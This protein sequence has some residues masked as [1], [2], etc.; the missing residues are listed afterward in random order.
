[1]KKA[2][3]AILN[4]PWSIADGWLETIASI[5]EREHEYAGN[6]EALQKKLGRPLGNTRTVTVRDGVAI[7]PIE[8]P[9]FSKANLFT[10]IS[11]LTSYDYLALE[12]T[13]AL[14]DPNIRAIIADFDTPGGSVNGASELSSMIR[15]ARGTKPMV[16]YVNGQMAS[17]GLWIGSA[18]DK[19][20]A[21]DTAQI[22]SVG[23]QMGATVREPR[24]GEKTYRFVSSQSPLKNADLG[25]DAGA[26]NAQKMVDDLAQVFIDTL[27]TNRNQDTE[28]VAEN[29]GQGAVFV[30]AEAL[31]RGMIDSISTF[32]TVF[33]T[34]SEE[35]NS[36]EYKQLTVAA[37]TENRPDLVA[38]I[39]EDAIATIDKP[40]LAAV[41]AEGATAERNRLLSIEALSMP[42]AEEII[43]AAKADPNA[44]AEATAVK[45]L[46]AV[47]AGAVAPK[48]ED[49]AAA[50]LKGIM[51]TEAALDKPVPLAAKDA[52]AEDPA[53]FI[54]A[55]AKAAGLGGM[56]Q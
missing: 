22:G 15:E 11:A 3:E 51:A 39:R 19:I 6:L 5:A 47:R 41:R 55:S 17:A 53:D 32:E 36:M 12:F 38:A 4:T 30:A 14:N 52:A 23:A 42:G 21:A 40:D 35:V 27:A 43:A 16:A 46:A 31:K 7:I 33:S 2:I 48:K 44:T 13:T 37:L 54:V 9:M 49:A 18:F 24:A 56:L 26:A 10:D 1:M 29:Y 34:L 25:T 28:Y 50:A 45:V 20:H 8:G